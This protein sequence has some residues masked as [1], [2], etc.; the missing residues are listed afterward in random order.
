MY[1]DERV[2]EFRE[3]LILSQADVEK[4]TDK[5]HSARWSFLWRALRSL[6]KELRDQM[7]RRSGRLA[8]LLQGYW[9]QQ[10]VPDSTE[11]YGPRALSATIV[12]PRSE[13]AK[14]A[15]FVGSLVE[16]PAMLDPR[17]FLA[18]VSE[19]EWRPC[20]SVV[21]R[22]ERIVGWLYFKEPLVAGIRTRL[23]FGDDSLSFIVMAHPEETE[24]VIR[25]GLKALLKHMMAV[26]LLVRSDRLPLFHGVQEIATVGFYRAKRHEHLELPRTYDELLAK[27][28]S[29]TRRNFRYYRR[30]S[31]LT[32][33]GF[34]PDLAFPDF[35]GAVGR[36]FPRAAYAEIEP[37]LKKCLAMIEAMPSRIVVGLRGDNGEWI[38][39][40]GGWRVGDRAILNMQLND[41]TRV[42]ESISLVLRSYLLEMLIKQGCRELVFWAGSSAPLSFY[43]TSP[44]LFIA[45]IDGGALPWRLFRQA[46]A[47]AS[48]LAP[49]IFGKTLKWI[50][51]GCETASFES[52]SE[53]NTL[54]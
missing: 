54:A 3:S 4:N 21:S 38:S 23:A 2:S 43:T 22:G 18:S 28:G 49:T 31:E 36:L 39:L 34:V 47:R 19:R 16:E 44:E 41:R 32:G 27:M 11:S 35:C 17:F 46:C 7:A 24:S 5:R 25:C 12:F 20:V 9:R 15:A 37:N 1:R 14:L 6:P 45:Y 26:R 13:I 48:T 10:R 33:H 29:R 51:P 53:L 40:A 42:R 52:K 8:T 50:V 30:K